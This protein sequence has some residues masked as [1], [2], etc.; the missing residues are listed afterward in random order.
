MSDN[1]G[2]GLARGHAAA[3]QV[4]VL[5]F[6]LGP[7]A[8]SFACSGSDREAPPVRQAP[9]VVVPAPPAPEP[10]PAKP[11]APPYPPTT[12]SL[13]VIRSVSV[14]ANPAEG[15]ERIGTI[16]QDIRVRWQRAERG[17]GCD[18][19]WIEI[20]PRGWICDRYLE[21]SER[22]PYGVELPRLG[23]DEL[24]PGTYGKV[25]GDKATLFVQDKTGALVKDKEL[26]GSITVRK[27][28]ETTDAK[29]ALFW[30]VAA[31]ANEYLPAKSIH[32]HEPSTFAGAR[33]GDETGLELPLVV[34]YHPKL[35]RYVSTYAVAR[36]GN[37][38]GHVPH[39]SFHRALETAIDDQARPV[40]YRIG[41]D[42]WIR[43]SDARLINPVAPPPGLLIGE[44]WLDVDLDTQT[45]IAYEGSIPVYATLISSGAKKTPTPPSLQRIWIKFSETDMKDLA[46]ESPYSVATVPWTQFY[47][48][49]LALHTTYWHDKLGITRSHGCINLAPVDARFLYFF[50]DPQVPPGW[51][52]ANGN[53]SNPGSLV[54]IRNAE[55]PD[56]PFEGY[57]TRI[58]VARG[59][60]LT[61][62]APTDT[63]DAADAAS[64][65]TA[66]GERDSTDARD[67]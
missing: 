29:G 52:M 59:V 34:A 42:Q 50:T 26:Q 66:T 41:Q 39:R 24:V 10:V 43:A 35:A 48:K 40:A 47:A 25:S 5:A 4:L 13:R 65:D 6:A 20:A 31:R 56:P 14:R 55:T 22:G 67:N 12:R 57:A 44:R 9:T 64:S 17:D 46:G 38:K 37:A 23:P 32:Q 36:G 21:P 60:S 49:D 27:Y 3:R 8:A 15:A 7:L 62:A 16:A 33:L 2:R 61:A 18:G 51:T 54:R 28:G 11:E 58:A 1:R 63:A 53:P 19:L 30:K 45:L